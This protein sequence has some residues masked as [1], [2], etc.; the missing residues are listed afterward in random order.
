MHPME[1]TGEVEDTEPNHHDEDSLE[2]DASIGDE[3]REASTNNN[4]DDDRNQLEAC[5]IYCS[6]FEAME[7]SFCLL[8]L[9]TGLLLDFI[10]IKP[11]QRPIPFQLLEEP[12][13]S[14]TQAYYVI[15]QM[16][17]E[18]LEREI[19]SGTSRVIFFRY[20]QFFLSSTR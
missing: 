11:R 20:P 8:L 2:D 3:R 7:L 6:S 4:D 18:L 17:G 13:S 5:R 14:S 15:N 9:I 1:F 10:A 16:Y 19:V 12:S